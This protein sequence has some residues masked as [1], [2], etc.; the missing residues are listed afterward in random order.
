MVDM[1]DYNPYITGYY[2]PLYNQPTNQGPVFRG[3]YVNIPVPFLCPLNN[4]LESCDW[5]FLEP[6]TVM[7]QNWMF[8]ETTTPPKKKLT[9]RP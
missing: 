2:N 8:G 6:Q 5:Y 4:P 3:L 7:I 9:V 1:V